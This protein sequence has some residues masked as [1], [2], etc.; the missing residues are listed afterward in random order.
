MGNPVSSSQFCSP[1][2]SQLARLVF[3]LASAVMLLN[4]DIIY[5][6]S[7]WSLLLW[8]GRGRICGAT[9]VSLPPRAVALLSLSHAA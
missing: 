7:A 8:P 9:T 3:L 6:C 4:G 5:P 1:K 2:S